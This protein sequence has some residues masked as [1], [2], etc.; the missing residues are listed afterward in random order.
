[1]SA[2]RWPGAARDTDS[3]WIWTARTHGAARRPQLERIGGGNI[4][5]AQGAGDHRAMPGNAESAI[6]RKVTNAVRAA[7]RPMCRQIRES[8]PQRIDSRPLHGGDHH[9]RGWIESGA[10]HQLLDFVG[11]LLRLCGQD[12]I[13]FADDDEAAVQ[14]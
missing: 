14:T 5:A 8:L 2:T 11:H 1:L 4:R 9:R 12:Q 3:P 13:D 10:H 7:R 6:D